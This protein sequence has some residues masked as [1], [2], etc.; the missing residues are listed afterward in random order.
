MTV[1]RP[2][3]PRRMGRPRWV[4]PRV[5]GGVLLVVASVAVGA[6]VV[7]AAAHT[8]PVW[9]ASADLAAGTVLTSGD[10]ARVEVNLAANGD[11]YLDAATVL[12]GRVLARA[13][14]AGELVPAAAVRQAEDGRIVSVPVAPD[15]MAPNVRHGSVIDLYLTVPAPAGRADTGETRLEQAGVTVQEVSGPAAGGLSG[16]AMP[17]FQVALLLSP[18]DAD[19]LVRNLPG[20]KPLVVLRSPAAPA[21]TSG[22]RASSEPAGGRTAGG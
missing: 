1:P 14:S 9:A 13:V 2:P 19:A 21:A 7:G 16:A 20:S 8:T 18:R 22:T 17:Q 10:V 12:A 3:A 5:V 11:R 15:R 4:N 6:R